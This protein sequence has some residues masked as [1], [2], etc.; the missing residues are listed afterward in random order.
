LA[1]ADFKNVIYS[2]ANIDAVAAGLQPAKANEP[3]EVIYKIQA[4]NVVTA[5]TIQANVYR[6]SLDDKVAISISTTNGLK[7]KEVWTCDP[8]SD[9]EAKVDLLSDVN[10]SYEVLVKVSLQAKDDPA[11]AILKSLQI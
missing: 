8:T 3:A 11:H 4:A 1:A 6:K 9:A 5:Q 10:G 7:W 2:S